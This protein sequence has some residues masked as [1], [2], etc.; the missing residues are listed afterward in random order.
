[1]N[2]R[3]TF[4]GGRT[5]AVKLIE[6][7]DLTKGEEI[8]YVDVTCLYPYANKY[9]PYPVGHPEFYS[10][11]QPSSL[12]DYFGFVQCSIVP[13]RYLYHTVLPVRHGDKLLFPLFMSCAINNL[14]SW[15]CPHNDEEREL[16]GTRCTQEVEKAVE[17]GYHIRHVYEVW[18]FPQT[19]TTLFHEYID[20]WLRIKQEA[21]GW[22]K[23]VGEDEEK[24]CQ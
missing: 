23:N 20:T 8:R 2:P 12:S 21:D 19:S 3:E 5:N 1:M 13:P 17:M 10:Q 9:K 6:K 22:P 4:F 14:K 18:N 15:H 24:R 16:V 7:A 11:V